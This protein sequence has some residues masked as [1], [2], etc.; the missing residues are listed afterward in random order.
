MMLIA[1]DSTFLNT[2]QQ[3]EY[4]LMPNTCY[5][6][7]TY[8]YDDTKGNDVVS[9]DNKY[10]AAFITET[11]KK[12]NQHY[13]VFRMKVSTADFMHLRP[14]HGV[15]ILEVAKHSNLHICT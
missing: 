11:T 13:N 12:V 4:Y 6:I 10:Y 7:H 5:T 9:Q 2:F 15:Y 14:L 3:N 1:A 8:A